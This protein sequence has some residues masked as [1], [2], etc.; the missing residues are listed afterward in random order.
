MNA[1]LLGENRNLSSSKSTKHINMHYYC[2]S[3]KVAK[4]K[5]RLEQCLAEEMTAD[6]FA[7]PLQGIFVKLQDK[8]MV[9][10]Q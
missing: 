5:M 8:I 6:F 3:N 1:I 4:G 9:I 7:K 2:I 10:K